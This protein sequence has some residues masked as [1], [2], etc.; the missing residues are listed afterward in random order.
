MGEL[1]QEVVKKLETKIEVSDFNTRIN[2][3]K[4]NYI[5]ETEVDY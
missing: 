5:D 4:L 1:W 2:I 3:G